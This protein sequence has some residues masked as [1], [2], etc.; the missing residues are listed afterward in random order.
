MRVAEEK[1]LTE[2]LKTPLSGHL[3]VKIFLYAD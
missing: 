3:E 1:Q 2:L